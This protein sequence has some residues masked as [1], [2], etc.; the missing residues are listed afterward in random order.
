MQTRGT[1][2]DLEKRLA[3]R[4]EVAAL[5]IARCSAP[6]RE[7]FRAWERTQVILDAKPPMSTSVDPLIASFVTVE[8]VMRTVS[9]GPMQSL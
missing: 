4:R 6:F 2:I 8:A 9:G 7:L 5:A 1:L 3:R